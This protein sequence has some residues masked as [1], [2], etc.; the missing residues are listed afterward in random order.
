MEKDFHYHL[1]YAAARLTEIPDPEIVA[2]SCQF[3]DDNNEGQF[4]IGGSD[5]FFPERLK[6]GGGYYYP[7]MTQSLSPKS[8]DP[9]VQKY[10]YVPFHFLPGENT[11]IIDKKKNP[12]CTTPNSGNAKIIVEKA[13]KGGNPYETG[14]AL[15]TFADTWSHQNFTGLR[16]EWNAIYP[17][18]DVFKSLVPNI[19]HAEAGHSPDVISEKWTDYRFKGD[20]REIDNRQRAFDAIETIYQAL[21]KSTGKGTPWNGVKTEFQKIINTTDYDDRIK[22]T[23]RF[24]GGTPNYTKDAWID[25]ALV[26]EGNEVVMRKGF[27]NTH[28]YRFHQAAKTHFAIVM[29]LIKGI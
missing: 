12:L 24:L 22:A 21:Q 17:W 16:E 14:I 26:T 9:Y 29:E 18:Y 19:G 20:A 11:V 27:E 4:S 6:A 3:V 23:S 2:H 5:T 7:V 25:D 15:H 13:L 8:L 1:T 10:V 28:W